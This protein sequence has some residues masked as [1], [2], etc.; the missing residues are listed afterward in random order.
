MIVYVESNF[1]LELVFAQEQ[2]RSCS[3][4]VKL[5]KEQHI[6]LILPTY[7]F[8][9]CY[10]RMGRRRAKRREIRE[11]LR[12]DIRELGRSHHLAETAQQLERL[13]LFL[14]ESAEEERRSFDEK[15]EEL[16]SFASWIPLT[17]D[18]LRLGVCLRQEMGLS[19]QDALILASVLKDLWERGESISVF[20]NKN[21]KDFGDPDIKSRLRELGCELKTDFVGGLAFIENALQRQVRREEAE[22]S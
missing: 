18:T 13:V 4:I 8:A 3:Q 11:H 17:K 9:E 19:Q 12:E 6:H 15:A 1:I 14:V 10:E 2:Q 5:A 22:S 21:S 16:F 7:S 20:I